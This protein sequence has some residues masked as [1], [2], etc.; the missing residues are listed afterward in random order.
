MGLANC[1][2]RMT[3][4][5]ASQ[6]ARSQK[7]V[8]SLWVPLLLGRLCFR[9]RARASA[10]CGSDW[11]PTNRMAERRTMRPKEGIIRAL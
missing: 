10:V 6:R 2:K 11:Q 3:P 5:S 7:R 4:K 1:S 8:S 9:A